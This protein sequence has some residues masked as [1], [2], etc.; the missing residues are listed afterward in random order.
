[1]KKDD[2][3]KDKRQSE[4]SSK[5]NSLKDLQKE[6]L[7][8]KEQDLRSLELS[9]TDE[10]EDEGLGDGNMHRSDKDLFSK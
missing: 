8:G 9:D 5:I 10:G 3:Q 6:E 4:K 2:N 1:M 7:S